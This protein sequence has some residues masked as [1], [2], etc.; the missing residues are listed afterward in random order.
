VA[1]THY[2]VLD[3]M[4]FLACEER[5]YDIAA[6]IAAYAD[7]AHEAHGQARRRP[8]D[9]R[10]R[11]AVTACLNEHV[12]PEWQTAATERRERLDEATACGLALGLC[13]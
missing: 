5:H 4:A 11:T 1:G 7:V 13:A 9:E 8:A 10:I 2:T 3:A 12:G 6:R